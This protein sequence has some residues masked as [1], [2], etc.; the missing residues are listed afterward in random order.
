LENGKNRQTFVLLRVRIL[1]GAAPNSDLHR[2]E[3]DR[4]LSRLGKFKPTPSFTSSR[5]VP[6]VSTSSRHKGLGQLA[7]LECRVLGIEAEPDG[8]RRGKTLDPAPVK[9]AFEYLRVSKHGFAAIGNSP[10][11]ERRLRSETYPGCWNPAVEV[12]R[13]FLERAL[14]SRATFTP[15]RFGKSSRVLR[16]PRRSESTRR[17]CLRPE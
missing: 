12:D 2:P 1:D 7:G 13:A 4:Q 14:V 8:W 11:L 3:S 10:I 16:D 6:L 5:C 15:C 9:P 17:D